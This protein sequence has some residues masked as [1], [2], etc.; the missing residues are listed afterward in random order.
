MRSISQYHLLSGNWHSDLHQQTQISLIHIISLAYSLIIINL[1]LWMSSFSW[2]FN[3]AEMSRWGGGGIKK[4]RRESRWTNR[5]RQPHPSVSQ[6]IRPHL[7][8]AD[9]LHVIT[10]T[11]WSCY[12]PGSN[13]TSAKSPSCYSHKS[14]LLR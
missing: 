4:G 8:P 10:L 11:S 5:I 13:R 7:Y 6:N 2:E 3:K 1:W 9:I 12:C 14:S